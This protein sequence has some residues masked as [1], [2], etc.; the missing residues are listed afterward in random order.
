MMDS[1]TGIFL[2]GLVVGFLV[3]FIAIAC[4]LWYFAQSYLQAQQRMWEKSRHMIE[5]NDP[6]NWWKYGKPRPED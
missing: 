5:E 1:E 4:L 3:A 6:D 2:A